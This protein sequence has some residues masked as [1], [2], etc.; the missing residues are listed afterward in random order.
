MHFRVP[1]VLHWNKI[2]S[3]SD[4]N[5]ETFYYVKIFEE[6]T[7]EERLKGEDNNIS[8]NKS[9]SIEKTWKQS[10]LCSRISLFFCFQISLH[11]ILLLLIF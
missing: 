5:M 9:I 4:I 1:F 2:V 6:N 3:N 8:D 10:I 7:E 11:V